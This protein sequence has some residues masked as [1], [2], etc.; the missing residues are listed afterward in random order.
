MGNVILFHAFI[1]AFGTHLRF[2][3]TMTL[4]QRRSR[5]L[6]TLVATALALS[7][8]GLAACG[9][10]DDK[11]PSQTL[12]VFAASSLTGT[13]TELGKKFEASRPGVKVNFSFGGSSDLVSQI[14]SGAPADVFAS[15][16]TKSMQKIVD[17]KLEGAL[18]INFAANTLQIVTPPENP[19]KVTTFKDLARKDLDL[20][21]CAPEVPCG[22]AAEKIETATGVDLSPVSEEQNVKDVLAKVT[23]GEADAGLVYVTD[24]KAAGDAVNGITFPEASNA[25]NIYPITTLKDAED[26]ALAADFMTFVLSAEGQAVLAEAGFAPAATTP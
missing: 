22:S 25:V 5:F 1:M 10:D 20:V 9:S 24:V 18:P 23:A 19:A 17:D 12:T 2:Y 4:V 16:D 7:T 13:F 15:A 3:G 21:V 26:A 8:F 14:Q 6:P 11:G